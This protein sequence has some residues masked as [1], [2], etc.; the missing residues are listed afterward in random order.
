[1]R[2]V[3]TQ[4]PCYAGDVSGAASA[5]YELG[6]MVVIHDPSGCNSTYNTHDETRWFD[7]ESLIFIS[8][9]NDMDAI[10][11]NDEKL[12]D[13]V[14]GAAQNLHPRFIALCNSPIPYIIGTDF[15][16]LA[17]MIA[18]QTGVPVFYIPTNGLHDYIDGAGRA[19]E[20]VA[21]MLVDDLDGAKRAH[22]VNILGLTPL[23][24]DA[25]DSAVSLEQKLIDAG[26]L[27]QSNWA[28]D[29]DPD[30]IRGAGG[31]A[32]NLV[33]SS[34][35]WRAA[36]VLRDRFGIPAVAGCPVGDFSNTLFDALERSAEDGQTRL[37]YLNGTQGQ[38]SEKAQAAV[39]GEAV[40]AG[41][42]AAALAGEQKQPVRVIVPTESPSALI[43]GQRMYAR[44]ETA[45]TTSL[46]GVQTV[47]ADP[48]YRP[49]VPEGA[50]LIPLHHFAF[51]GRIGYDRA[52]NLFD[53][54]V[55]SKL[56][57]EIEYGNTQ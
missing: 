50:E 37:P 33:V 15:E 38:P 22:S 39:I 53:N 14:V 7:K 29:C 43:F 45:L 40:Q 2:Q 44:G 16:G 51:S 41:S 36:K 31:A 12:V 1:M 21:E 8:G 5:L 20:A 13:D 11:G 54:N 23:D 18:D 42:I 57:K 25:P 30:Q 32:V 46:S 28:L 27:V 26:W 9:L 52:V 4:V 10:V 3:Y 24:F 19:F 47:I 35:G 34:T 56:T 6:G 49:L 48:L 55:F 17:E